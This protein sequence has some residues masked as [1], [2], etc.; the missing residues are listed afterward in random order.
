MYW[1]TSIGRRT[2]KLW[3]LEERLRKPPSGMTIWYGTLTQNLLYPRWEEPELTCSKVYLHLGF[4]EVLEGF[5]AVKEDVLKEG[6]LQ[7]P[8]DWTGMSF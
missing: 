4:K 8:W 1:I 5:L 7:Q 2:R 6:N 3:P